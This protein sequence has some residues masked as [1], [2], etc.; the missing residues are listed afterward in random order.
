M[1]NV[2]L[3]QGHGVPGQCIY[4]ATGPHAVQVFLQHQLMPFCP[5]IDMCRVCQAGG[6]RVL[7]VSG[8]ATRRVDKKTVRRKLA[9][10]VPVL[11]HG[12]L[13]VKAQGMLANHSNPEQHRLDRQEVDACQPLG[14]P[15]L[16]IAAYRVAV[17]VNDTHAGVGCDG[18]RRQGTHQ[19]GDVV[20]IKQI[21]I[22]EEQ[23]KFASSAIQS[24]VRGIG[25]VQGW[26]RGVRRSAGLRTG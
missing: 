24:Q 17:S 15:R 2:K 26:K 19:I 23:T 1:L 10:E 3:I 16:V 8:T 7:P 6:T 11:E 9:P 18:R 13:A 14:A 25:T 4:Q 20:Y 21:I 22:I 12:Q 5:V